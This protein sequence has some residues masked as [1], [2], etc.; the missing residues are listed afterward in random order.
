MIWWCF[1]TLSAVVAAGL[2]FGCYAAMGVFFACIVVL[3]W[4]ELRRA[5]VMS[6]WEDWSG[7]EEGKEADDD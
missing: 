1:L 3:M 4:I 5:P 7:E 6:D 2:F